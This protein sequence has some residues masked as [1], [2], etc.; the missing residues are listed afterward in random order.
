M[1]EG[2][3]IGWSFELLY[4]IVTFSVWN[5]NDLGYAVLFLGSLI[6]FRVFVIFVGVRLVIISWCFSS[7]LVYQ[8]ILITMLIDPLFIYLPIPS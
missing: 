7:V 4:G 6:M 3:V 8:L 1:T 2:I 5:I